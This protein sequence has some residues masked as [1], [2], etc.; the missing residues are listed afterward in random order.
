MW[1]TKNEFTVPVSGTGSAAWEAG[2]ANL[3]EPGD[4]HLIF[5][6]GYFGERAI[7]MH[8]R[9]TDNVVSVDKP[10]GEWFSYEEIEAAVLEHKP[11]LIWIVHA[12]T[13]TGVEHP[14]YDGKI[15]ELCRR[16]DVDCL[17]MLDTVTSICGLPVELDKWGVDCAYAGTQKCM[18]CP[19]GVAPLTIGARGLAKMDA[20]KPESGKVKNWYL[21]MNMIK[22][23]ISATGGGPRVYHHT[24]PISMVYAIREALTLVAEEGLET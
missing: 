10:Y 2:V 23:Y 12:E 21:D 20:R 9:Y 7:D 19:P 13:S 3:T 6:N 17:F 8:G 15:G 18:G 16:P 5:N 22:K 14:M 1:Q 4:K 11:Q 24:A